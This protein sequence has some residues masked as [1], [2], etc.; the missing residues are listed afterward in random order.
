MR[1][2]V[3]VTPDGGAGDEIVAERFARSDAG[4]TYR[5]FA[6]G[7]E[8][9]PLEALGAAVPMAEVFRNVPAGA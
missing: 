8:G 3:L 6:A 1:E 2:I 7:D 9:L 5:T 4:W